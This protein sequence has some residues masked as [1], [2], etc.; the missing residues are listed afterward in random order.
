MI[1]LKNED[2]TA[3]KSYIYHSKD[4]MQRKKNI[5][6]KLINCLVSFNYIGIRQKVLSVDRF[7]SHGGSSFLYIYLNKLLFRAENHNPLSQNA[8]RS[9]QDGGVQQSV[10]HSLTN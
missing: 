9:V 10:S 1:F 4:N 8:T 6:R 2:A 7:C 5:A 3:E